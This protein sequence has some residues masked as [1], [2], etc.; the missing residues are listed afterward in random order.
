MML[1]RWDATKGF[2]HQYHAPL[3][4][5]ILTK[6]AFEMHRE[7]VTKIERNRF[8]HIVKT[9]LENR[10]YTADTEQ[11]RDEIFNRSGL[12]R[13]T[14]DAI[15]FRH[16]MIQEFFAGRGIST[17]EFLQTVVADPWWRR[18]VVFY[19]GENPY[20]SEAL[21][22]TIAGLRDKSVE[23]IYNAA[24]TLG[25]ALQ[26]CYLVE[27][28]H[29]I[30]I[31]R[32][33]IDGLANARDE[34]LNMDIMKGR[35]KAKFIFYY[36][37]GR[38]SVALSVLESRVQDIVNQLGDRKLP[39]D[40]ADIRMF[41]I[42]VGLIECGALDAADALLKKFKPSD[43]TLLLCIHLGCY[44]IQHVRMSN[45]QQQETA[46]K[47]SDSLSAKINHL[48]INL[49]EEM[50]TELLEIRQGTVKTLDE[51]GSPSSQLEEPQKPDG[52]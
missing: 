6:V 1:G 16:L 43:P 35:P 41:W 30:D 19:F 7:K 34:F 9:E 32:W 51:M 12:F 22:S 15:E 33:V 5:F 23:D 2:R 8:D 24:L 28:K 49:L 44:L 46:R 27:V 42:I 50:K 26:A 38:D 37:V 45:K 40:D 13:I 14:D 3:K 18:A 31:Y 29:K 48:K 36:L 21:Y 47:I 4:D 10:G 20:N 25:L 11:L 17:S 39:A 52:S